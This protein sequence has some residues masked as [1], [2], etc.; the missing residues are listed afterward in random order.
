MDDRKEK[1]KKYFAI[2]KK[3]NSFGPSY[4]LVGDDL[5]FVKGLAELINCSESFYPCGRCRNCQ[6]V[7][8]GVHPDVMV[9]ERGRKTIKIDDV[10]EVQEF[11]SRKSFQAEKKIVIIDN[12][13]ML[14]PAASNSFLKTMEEPPAGSIIMLISSRPDLIIPTILSRC[15]KIYLPYQETLPNKDLVRGVKDLLKG[16]D[17]YFAKRQDLARFLEGSIVLLRDYLVFKIYGDRNRLVYE[18]SFDIISR[19]NYPFSEATLKIDNLLR[20]YSGWENINLNLATNLLK[21][22]FTPVY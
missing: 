9:V 15:R 10:K 20:I 17:I 19:L 16:A 4:L 22:T 13:H 14:T 6:M 8:G 21:L 2:L 7:A 12:A 11:L 1:I 5:T 18:D 3:H